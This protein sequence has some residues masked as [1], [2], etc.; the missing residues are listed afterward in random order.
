[1]SRDDDRADAAEQFLVPV[2]QPVVE[3]RPV[4]ELV[5]DLRVPKRLVV[6]LALDDEFGVGEEEVGATVVGVE[7]GVHDMG[8]VGE[9]ETEF[10]EP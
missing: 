10:G 5:R 9:L 7:V 2:E 4:K 8:D 1:V 6:L 3:L